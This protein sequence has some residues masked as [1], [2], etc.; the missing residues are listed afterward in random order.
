MRFVLEID[1]DS[2]GMTERPDLA[3]A[4]K[5]RETADLVFEGWTSGTLRDVN[6]VRVG[7]F[8]LTVDPDEDQEDEE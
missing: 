1:S 4:E 5:L 8:T 2:V 6:G 3:V 7:T